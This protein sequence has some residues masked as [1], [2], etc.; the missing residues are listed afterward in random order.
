MIHENQNGVH[1]LDL[2]EGFPHQI[3][4]Y[5]KGIQRGSTSSTVGMHQPVFLARIPDSTTS[6]WCHNIK[7][8]VISGEA[9]KHQEV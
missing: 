7:F 3:P 2:S 1:A 5:V 9:W 8:L 6:L 4:A